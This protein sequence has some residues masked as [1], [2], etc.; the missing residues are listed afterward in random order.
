MNSKIYYTVNE[1]IKRNKLSHAI[2]IDAGSAAMRDDAALYIATAFVCESPLPCG[3]CAACQKVKSSVH[4]DVYTYDPEAENERV[5]KIDVIRNIRKDAFILPNEAKHKVYILKGA[6]KMNTAAQNALLKTL[7]EPPEHV[8][9]ILVCESRASLLETI[10][11]RVTPFNLGADNYELTSEYAQ[12]ADALANS[13]AVALADV[14][15]LEFMRLTA[16]FEKD[17]DILPPT[18]SS[19]QLIFRDAVALST[20]SNQTL[21]SHTDTAKL[22]ASKL[23]IKALMTL[24]QNT[25]HFSECLVRNANKNL[26]I[27]RFC[28]VLRDTAY[29]C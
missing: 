4:P 16:V 23:T 6:D 26:L 8:R 22:L 29:G 21:S 20:G 24:V 13:L 18:L 15:E 7:E 14:T 19:L 25:E 28:S 27:T 9:F 1:L 12:K 17:K 5:F 11:S 2:L 3:E 10:M